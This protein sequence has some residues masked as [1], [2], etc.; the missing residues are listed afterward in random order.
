[1]QTKLKLIFI[2][3]LLIGISFISLYSL[4][5]WLLCI[6]LDLFPL[7]EIIRNFGIPAFLLLIP[8]MVWLRPRINLLERKRES[9]NLSYDMIAWILILI[10]LLISQE[11]LKTATGKLTELGGID[12]ID[13][14]KKTKFYTVR[15]YFVSKKDGKYHSS[16]ELSASKN[17]KLIMNVY[18][19]F[20]MY[21]SEENTTGPISAWLG[22]KYREDISRWISEEE[23]LTKF[24]DFLVR[25]QKDLDARNLQEFIY[26]DRIGSSDDLNGYQEAIKKKGSGNGIVLVPVHKP[27]SE[28]NGSRLFWMCATFIIGAFIWLLMLIKP[29]LNQEKLQLYLKEKSF[30]EDN[31]VRKF[32]GFFIPQKNCFVTPILLC[33]NVFIFIAMAL[34]GA[35]FLSLNPADLLASGAT[36]APNIAEGEY[37]RLLTG[38]FLHAGIAELFFNMCGLYFVGLLLEPIL[39][40]LKFTLAYLFIGVLASLASIYWYPESLITGA[41]GGIFGLNGILLAFLMPKTLPPFLRDAFLTVATIYLLTALLTNFNIAYIGALVNG[42]MLGILIDKDKIAAFNFMDIWGEEYIDNGA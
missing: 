9:R 13:N 8:I 29:K 39:G 31:E 21:E 2:P 16:F 18:L 10:P 3:F 34:S 6:K 42:F 17:K 28:R 30:A 33:L 4:L 32:I 37:W 38:T 36:Y 27:F 26:L 7:Q 24:R 35:G 41:Y 15:D 11:Y 23:T 12:G 5:N 14:Y 19:A 1:M 40:R 22:I 25:S 20:P